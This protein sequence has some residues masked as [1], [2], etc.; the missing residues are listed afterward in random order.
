[1]TLFEKLNDDLKSAMKGGNR[2]RLEVL[3]FI[4]SGVQGAQ[5]DKNAKQ[6]G[7]MLTDDEIIAILQKEAK[8]RKEATELFRKGNRGDLVKKEEADLAVIYEYIPKG[9]SAA[10]IAAILD[11]LMAQGFNDFN[12]L[13]RE[14]MKAMKGRADGKTVGDAIKEKLG[15]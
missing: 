7:A 3:R 14:A 2:E 15:Q 6:P 5:K 10:E 13:M 11:G 12:S 4:L 1:M 8:R 9:L